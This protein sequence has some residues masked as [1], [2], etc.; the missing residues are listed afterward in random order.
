MVT[1]AMEQH[2]CPK[3]V[4]ERELLVTLIYQLDAGQ[5]IGGGTGIR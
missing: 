1:S 3:Q 4:N 5:T 2:S